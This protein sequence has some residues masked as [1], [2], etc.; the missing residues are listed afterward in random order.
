MGQIEQSWKMHFF[1]RRG[2]SAEL[3]FLGGLSKYLDFGPK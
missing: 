2:A 1:G 3:T